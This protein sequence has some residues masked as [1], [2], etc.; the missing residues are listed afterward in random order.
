MTSTGV[1]PSLSAEARASD[2]GA[3][4]RADVIHSHLRVG[5]ISNGVQ[6]AHA[7]PLPQAQRFCERGPTRHHCV[8]YELCG[9]EGRRVAHLYIYAQEKSPRPR[10]PGPA[11]RPAAEPHARRTPHRATRGNSDMNSEHLRLG[12]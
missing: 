10:P 12:S 5:G 8:L 6:V 11:A 7:P 2:P 4:N 9:P 3:R 1:T